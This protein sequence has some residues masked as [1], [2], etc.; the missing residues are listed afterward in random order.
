MA[1]SVAEKQDCLSS[2]YGWE[3][4]W[5]AAKASGEGGDLVLSIDLV[6]FIDTADPPVG[7]D[8]GSSLQGKCPTD[9]V[10]DHRGCQACTARGGAA[11]I[12]PSWGSTGCSLQRTLA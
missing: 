1:M 10:S 2:P 7:Q 6:K 11:H 8:Q 5:C 3:S 12:Q 9:R 4:D